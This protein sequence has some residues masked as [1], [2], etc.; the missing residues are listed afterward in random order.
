MLPVL[1]Q[2]GNSLLNPRKDENKFYQ[3][4]SRLKEQ[5]ISEHLAIKEKNCIFM[6][7]DSEYL[8][9][10]AAKEGLLTV[11]LYFDYTEDEVMY[12]TRK[13]NK[14]LEYKVP[15]LYFDQ[16]IHRGLQVYVNFNP[17]KIYQIEIAINPNSAL[18]RGSYNATSLDTL[19]TMNTVPGFTITLKELPPNTKFAFDGKDDVGKTYEQVKKE[20][21]LYDHTEEAK[22]E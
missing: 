5:I 11:I 21:I 1:I 17:G 15:K 9:P 4:R 22:K 10:I 14:N 13:R 6:A 3:V 16:F 19:E 12:Y 18:P 8:F 20:F 2:F 7:M